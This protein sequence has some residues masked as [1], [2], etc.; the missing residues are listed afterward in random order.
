[1]SSV[2]IDVHHHFNPTFKDNEGNPWSVAMAL[3]ELDRNNVTTAIASLGPLKQDNSA[4]HHQKVRR[5]NEWAKTICLDHKGKF[6]LFALLPMLNIDIALREL[7]HA[8][9][10]LNV[11]GIALSTNEG[12]IWLSDERNETVFAEL[13][14]RKAVV[15]VHPAPTTNC[16]NISKAYGGNAISSPWLNSRSIPRASSLAFSPRA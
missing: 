12:D 10:V 9:D 14:R 6:G 8:Y 11:D 4:D 13:N 15:F 5:W 1:M 16:S 3:E 7:E 2:V